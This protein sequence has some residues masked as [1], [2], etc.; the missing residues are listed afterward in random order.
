MIRWKNSKYLQ[1]RPLNPN[2]QTHSLGCPDS[3]LQ[4]DQAGSIGSGAGIPLRPRRQSQQSYSYS[5]DYGIYCDENESYVVI[6]H[7][8]QV[9]N[10]TDQEDYSD[11]GAQHNDCMCYTFFRRCELDLPP[12]D[13]S[14]KTSKIS[15]TLKVNQGQKEASVFVQVIPILFKHN[16]PRRIF[17]DIFKRNEA[18]GLDRPHCGW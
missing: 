5:K 17:P 13:H 1:R 4:N 3:R 7:Q 10:G 2:P 9:Y 11:N 8:V 16:I 14:A 12:W 6:C 15:L 18:C